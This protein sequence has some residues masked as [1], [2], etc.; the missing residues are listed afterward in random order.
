M[1][2]TN[3]VPVKKSALWGMLSALAVW[4]P[5]LLADVFDEY[6]LHASP[7]FSLPIFCAAPVVLTV[8][9]VKRRRADGARR[10]NFAVWLLCYAAVFTLV[11]LLICTEINTYD[12]AVIVPQHQFGRGLDFNGIEYAWFGIPALLLFLLNIGIYHF[13]RFMKRGLARTKDDSL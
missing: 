6:V 11:W 3:S 10:R 5:L 8:L 9:Y 4:L 2:Q 13:S 1:Q 12:I 7:A